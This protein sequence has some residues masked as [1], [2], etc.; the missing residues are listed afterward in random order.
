MLVGAVLV[1]DI[2]MTFS[3]KSQSRNRAMLC[4]LCSLKLVQKGYISTQE[5]HGG[6]CHSLKASGGTCLPQMLV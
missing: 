6:K 3:V 2:E 5:Q 4:T 1:E